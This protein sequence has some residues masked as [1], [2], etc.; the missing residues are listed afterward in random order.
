MKRKLYYFMLASVMMLVGQAAWADLQ[1]NESGAYLIGSKADL[2]AWTEMAGYESTDVVLTSDIEGLDFMLCNNSTSYSGTFDGQGHTITLNYDFEG[3][4]TGMFYNFAGTVKN[5]VVGG[6]IRA[7]Y[8]NCAGFAAWN[9]SDNAQFENC[10]CI[11]SIDVDYSANASN[12][13]FVGYSARNCTFTNCISGIKVSGNQGYNHGFAG[14]VSSGKVMNYVNCISIAEVET[15]NTYAW[16]NTPDR[17]SHTNCYCLQQ[18][19]DAAAAPSGVTYI[20]YDQVASGELCFKANGDQS[21]IGAPSA[22]C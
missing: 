17:V 16:S 20:T 1:Q 11:V 7:S 22:A 12:A 2:Q 8:K 10:V 19:A 5:L 9:W 13:G 14:W 3:K 4:Q 18:D 6:N 15:M 21:S